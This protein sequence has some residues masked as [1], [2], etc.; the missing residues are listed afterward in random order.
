MSRPLRAAA[1]ALASAALLAVPAASQAATPKP[2]Y[3]QF[4]GCPNR[5]DIG[6]CQTA[7]ITGGYFKLGKKTVPITKPI[8][9]TGGLTNGEVPTLAYEAGGGLK[10]DPIK[11]PGGLSGMTGLSEA[12]LNLITFGSNDVYATP[13]LVSDPVITPDGI[14]L[15]LRIKLKNNFLSANCS[16]GSAAAP[17]VIRLITGTTTPP[18]GF[19]PLTGNS[20]TDT[21]YDPATAILKS[22]GVKYV[23]N[24]FS[25]PGASGCGNYIGSLNVGFINDLVNST[26]GLPATPGK[27]EAVQTGITIQV[28]LDLT[29][30]FG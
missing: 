3:T 19:T 17:V 10:S 13:E 11:V 23:D 20:G 4:K 25:V 15:P 14:N 24:T 5:P 18:A 8:T 7:T 22:T 2:G 26:I 27:S 9:L 16:I 29:K 6:A 12:F 30:V 28:A 21:A 1:A